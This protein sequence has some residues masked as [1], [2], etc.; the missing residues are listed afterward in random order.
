MLLCSNSSMAVW[1]RLN[2][3]CTTCLL[4]VVWRGCFIISWDKIWLQ[5]LI[6]LNSPDMTVNPNPLCRAQWLFSTSFFSLWLSTAKPSHGSLAVSW[7]FWLFA[8][9]FASPWPGTPNT[10]ASS[11]WCQCQAWIPAAH[12]LSVWNLSPRCSPRSSITLSSRDKNKGVFV[13]WEHPTFCVG[14]IWGWM[15]VS[16]SLNTVG[17]SPDVFQRRV[18]MDRRGF[19]WPPL[20]KSSL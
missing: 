9:P 15:A 13:I 4:L 18:L 1:V 8:A 14:L 16:P 6:D 7:L 3:M 10:A 19:V 2:R 11:A 12:L 17:I 5:L 20:L